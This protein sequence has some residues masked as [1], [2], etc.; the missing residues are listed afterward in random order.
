MT[1]LEAIDQRHSIRAYDG[2]ILSMT[3]QTSLQRLI[4]QA[5]AD[6]R[7]H[8]QLVCDETVAF[9]S[10]LARYGSF[11]GVANYLVMA[12]EDTADLDERIGYYGEHIV[13]EAECMGLNTCWAGLTYRKV[14]GTYHLEPGEKI[15]AYI[16]LGYGIGKAREHRRKTVE[17]LSNADSTTPE[18]FRRGIEAV[19][20][21]P[22]AV[23]QQKFHFAFLPSVSGEAPRI[24]ATKG[25]SLIGYTQMDLGIAKCHFEIGA[26]TRDFIW[27]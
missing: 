11:R 2:Q 25:F 1:L 10:L 24:K 23:N 12:G 13:L 5:N 7:L 21:A 3:H 15:A 14:P 8:I 17:Q 27:C 16:A 6:G 20:K 19:V 4:D 18:W 26:G 9:T 22:T